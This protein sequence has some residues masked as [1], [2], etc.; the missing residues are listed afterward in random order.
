MLSRKFKTCVRCG[1]LIAAVL[2]ATTSHAAVSTFTGGDA[3]EGLDLQG[4]FSY[5]VNVQGPG[6][7]QVGDALFTSEGATL[8]YSQNAG[9]QISNW[10]NPSFGVSSHDNN[11]ETVMQS[12]R[13]GAPAGQHIVTL[14]N[15]T[16]GQDYSMQ[17]LYTESCCNRGFDVSVNGALVADDFN[18]P[19]TQGGINGSPTNG[20]IVSHNFTAS[21]TM[22]KVLMNGYG[23]TFPDKNATLSGLTLEN[24]GTT[25]SIVS[26]VAFD[27]PT[28]A[29]STYPAGA[30]FDASKIVDGNTNDTQG[31]QWLSPNGVGNASVTI[32]LQ[33]EFDISSFDL[34]NTANA[35]YL[36]RATDLFSIDVAGE[37]GLFSEALSSR[38]LQHYTAGF[39]TE[40]VDLEQI[41]FVRFNMVSY[42]DPPGGGGAAGGGLNELVVNG[43]LSGAVPVPEPA[44]FLVWALLGICLT[45]YGYRRR[46]QRS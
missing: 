29:T 5:A 46:R 9:S 37:D 17:L 6:G 25:N 31:N 1:V 19:T 27:K 42:K 8:G 15:L 11:L 4:V 43:T 30:L 14:G 13:H 35:Q 41:Q 38:S 20:V 16:V 44:S 39:Q 3:G 10:A 23:T 33:D 2:A 24:L 40:A 45:G 18:I 32:D 22:A 34:L 28:S 21:S 12:I 36:D 7:L 26:N